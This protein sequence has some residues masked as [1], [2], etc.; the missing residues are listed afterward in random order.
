[1]AD[2]KKV[3]IFYGLRV[4]GPTT[5]NNGQQ[6]TNERALV[7]YRAQ[8]SHNAQTCSYAIGE[9]RQRSGP[10]CVSTRRICTTILVSNARK[11]LA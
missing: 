10:R 11:S 5:A 2:A 3:L 8:L 9:T 7:S 4:N 6:R 1:M